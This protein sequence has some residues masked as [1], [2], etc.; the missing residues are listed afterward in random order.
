MD[1]SRLK[2][3]NLIEFRVLDAEIQVV[4]PEIQVMDE[5]VDDPD[6]EENLVAVEEMVRII[7]T[8]ATAT[9]QEAINT[10]MEQLTIAF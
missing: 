9:K 2:E 10:D 3:T 7:G 4:D 6:V 5:A 8:V 1:V